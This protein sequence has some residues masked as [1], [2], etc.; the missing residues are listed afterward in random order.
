MSHLTESFSTGFLDM[1]QDQ[2]LLSQNELNMYL[3]DWNV[4][5]SIEIYSEYIHM[6]PL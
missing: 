2:W 1:L 6:L 5:N 4:I 3:G